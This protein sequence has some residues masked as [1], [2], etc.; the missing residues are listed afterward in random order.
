VEAAGA[1]AR[2]TG[3]DPNSLRQINDEGEQEDPAL[4]RRKAEI[5]DKINKHKKINF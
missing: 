3:D 5:L 2:G 1:A 4:L